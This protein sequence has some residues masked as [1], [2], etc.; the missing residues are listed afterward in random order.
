M[1]AWSTNNLQNFKFMRICRFK[2]TKRNLQ[3]YIHSLLNCFSRIFHIWQPRNLL[4]VLF[5][6]VTSRSKIFTKTIFFWQ[7][8]NFYCLSETIYRRFD[9]K[10]KIVPEY[11]VFWAFV[12]RNATSKFKNLKIQ[13]DWNLF[14]NWNLIFRNW[15][16]KT[17]LLRIVE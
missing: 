4:V 16:R 15:A 1:F 8:R 3:F 14:E 12:A 5:Q 2:F 6:I 9:V 17:K 11:Y 13:V 10:T 7:T